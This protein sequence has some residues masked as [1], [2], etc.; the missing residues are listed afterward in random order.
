METEI[1]FPS[2]NEKKFLDLAQVL[3][4]KKI[5][6]VYKEIKKVKKKWPGREIEAGYGVLIEEKN[7]EKLRKKILQIKNKDQ[8]CLVIIKAGDDGFNRFVFE[9]TKADVIFDLELVHRKDATHFRRS[10]LDQVLCRI[11]TEKEKKV[12]LSF[13]ELTKKAV[14]LGRARQNIRFCRKFRVDWF[15]TSFAQEPEMMRSVYD[16]KAFLRSL[17]Q[18]IKKII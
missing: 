2:G 13:W 3:G 17:E 10:G 4:F 1:V 6:F 7:K 8:N 12:G 15:L 11:A 14:Y 9:K 16:L 18:P 5:I